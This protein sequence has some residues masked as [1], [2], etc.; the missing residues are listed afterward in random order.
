M[1]KVRTI[2]PLKGRRRRIF[3]TPIRRGPMIIPT[4]FQKPGESVSSWKNRI[5]KAWESLN[6]NRGGGIHFEVRG[7]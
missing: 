6:G 7:R 3:I 4:V 5:Q 1:A 2:A